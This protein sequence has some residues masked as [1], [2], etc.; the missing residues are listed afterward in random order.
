MSAT[1]DIAAA[2]TMQIAGFVQPIDAAIESVTRLQTVHA[3]AMTSIAS[4][5]HPVTAAAEAQSDAIRSAMEQSQAAYQPM[6][7]AVKRQSEEV[8]KATTSWREHGSAAASVAK[9][10]GSIILGSMRPISVVLGLLSSKMPGLRMVAFWTGVVASAHK[11]LANDARVAAADAQR[12]AIANERLARSTERAAA[13]QKAKASAGY[14]KT[15]QSNGGSSDLL[16]KAGAMAVEAAKSNEK[17]A[18]SM[19]LVGG[20]SAAAGLAVSAAKGIKDSA[21]EAQ[22]SIADLSGLLA[23]RAVLATIAYKSGIDDLISASA[24]HVSSDSRLMK[25]I[26]NTAAALGGVMNTAISRYSDMTKSA[27]MATITFATGFDSIE[28][29]VDAAANKLSE[30]GEK[31]TKALK[32]AKNA[33]NEYSLKAAAG[34]QKVREYFVGGNM[35]SDAYVKEGLALIEMAESSAKLTEKMEKQAAAHKMINGVIDS[36]TAAQK[37]NAE[38][39]RLAS[40]ESQEAI[41]SEMARLRKLPETV[42]EA[43]AASKEFKK[44]IE[45]QV[46]AISKSQES[47]AKPHDNGVDQQLKSMEESLQR[48]KLGEDAAAIAAAQM[49]GATE[50]QLQKMTM[51]QAETENLTAAKKAQKDAEEALERA[52]EKAK[53]Q[54]EQGVD[55][56][57]KLKDEIDVLTGAATH[58]QIAMREMS[59]QGFSQDQIDEVGQLEA[60]LEELRKHEKAGQD[61]SGKASKEGKSDSKAALLGSSDAA[62]IFLR[63]VGGTSSSN[64]QVTEQKK[65]N[66]FLARQEAM[67]KKE[68]S[69]WPRDKAGQG[70]AVVDFGGRG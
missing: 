57:N 6:N 16:S 12:L 32:D 31:A 23:G 20:S 51:L 15:P 46:A 14:A 36:A 4:Q 25:S 70:V 66:E 50:E 5:M 19:E 52:A 61:G 27:V 35:D 40:L 21:S 67:M 44:S 42:D 39:T 59:R 64:P 3:E 7:A 29:L 68:S 1:Y 58:A 62:S 65:T 17:L 22:G 2:I 34:L 38:I 18:Q 49:A 11:T 63:G 56:I 28:S 48:L 24:K 43:T 9:T 13:A 26:F 60:R 55:R 8:Q 37:K 54:H 69:P 53:Q 30:F 41:D 33:I 45:E 10:S 47:L